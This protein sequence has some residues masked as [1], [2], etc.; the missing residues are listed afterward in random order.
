[1]RAEQS[2]ILAQTREQGPP[3]APAE[4]VRLKIYNFLKVLKMKTTFN[5]RGP[6][7]I[8]SDIFQQPPIRS[9]SNFILKLRGPNQN[10]KLLEMK[11]TSNG[12][13]L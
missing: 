4:I 2:S 3:L 11:T 1:M 6:K 12:R 5:R 13:R 7:N 8:N 9:F 10:D